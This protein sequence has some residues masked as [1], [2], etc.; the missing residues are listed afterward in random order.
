MSENKKPLS[1]EEKLEQLRRESD[2]LHKRIVERQD[3][4]E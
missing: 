4:E 3:E 1:E 2:E